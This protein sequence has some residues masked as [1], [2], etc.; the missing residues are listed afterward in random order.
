MSQAVIVEAVRA[1]IGRRIG[2]VAEIRPDDLA[3]PVLGAVVER[4]GID[5]A[6]VEDV[7]LGC[8]DEVGEQ[9]CNLA[10]NA[11]LIAGRPLDVCGVSPDRMCGSGRQAAPVGFGMIAAMCIGVRQGIAPLIERL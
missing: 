5:P 6:V 9:A 1:P 11:P 8:V 10:R 7:I 2:K 4:A 3:A